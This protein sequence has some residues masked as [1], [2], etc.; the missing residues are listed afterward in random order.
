VN[1]GRRRLIIIGGAVV[2]AVVAALVVWFAIDRTPVAHRPQ[3]AHAAALKPGDQRL[4]LHAGGRTRHY[5]LYVPTSLAAAGRPGLVLVFH[6]ADDPAMIGLT[7]ATEAQV[8]LDAPAEA[9]HYLVAYLE[10]YQNSWNDHAGDSAAESAGVDDVAFATAVVKD[11]ARRHPIDSTRVSAVGFSNGALFVD[12]LGCE[13]ADVFHAIVPVEGELPVEVA[14]TCAP[15]APLSVLAV[16]G[17]A[18][19]AISY[20]GG[21]FYGNFGGG[22]TL[23]A[24][25]A[26]A[27]WGALNGC[28]DP[29]TTALDARTKLDAFQ[30]CDG[31]VTVSL[32]TIDGGGHSWPPGLADI[33]A[34]AM[35]SGG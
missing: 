32:R 13:R 23:S 18:D 29:Q 27:R 19:D 20:D 3:P 25:D 24:P 31:G 9:G 28:S 26:L 22:S 15:S 17:T 8:A 11:V 5:V 12:L 6:G 2:I 16:H 35:P 1:W 10:G 7:T 34:Q 14:K 4:S 33:V 21:S 30:K